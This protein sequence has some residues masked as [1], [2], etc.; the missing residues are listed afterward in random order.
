MSQALSLAPATKEVVDDC[1]RPHD[2][3]GDEDRFFHTGVPASRVLL[4]SRG[5]PALEAHPLYIIG[6]RMPLVQL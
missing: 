6:H 5:A 3:G 4:R 2:G 1:E